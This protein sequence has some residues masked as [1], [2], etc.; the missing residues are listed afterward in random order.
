MTNITIRTNEQIA[1][2][3]GKLAKAMDRPKNW[4][5]ED[6]LKQYIAEQSWQ[7]AGIKQ[8]QK[9][10]AEGKSVAFEKVVKKLRTKIKRKQQKA[11]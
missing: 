11:K 4:V 5:I 8:A 7:V 9:S 3:I 6:A 2:Q 10:L 1:D